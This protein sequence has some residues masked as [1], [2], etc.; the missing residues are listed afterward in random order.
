ML[1]DF[2]EAF[3]KLFYEFLAFMKL[4]Y[5]FLSLY[6]I[7]LRIFLPLLFFS[8]NFVFKFKCNFDGII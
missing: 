2:K 1:V 5:K 7:I 3:I 8:Q 6:Q 4:F